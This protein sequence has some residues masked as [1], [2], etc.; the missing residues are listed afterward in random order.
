MIVAVVVAGGTGSRFGVPEGKQVAVVSGLPIVTHT[1]LA[2]EASDSIDAIV[3][4]THPDRVEEYRR[5]VVEELGVS[6]VVAVVA[7]GDTRQDSVA[8]GTEAAGDDATVLV[9]HDGARPLVTPEVIEHAVRT[10]LGDT[11]LDGVIVGHPAVD[12]IHEVSRDDMIE[13]TPDRTR[14]WTAQT[15]QVFRADVL[16]KALTAAGAVG[17]AGTDDASLV[18][19][20]GGSVRMIE[21]PRDNIKVTLPEDVVLVEYVLRQRNERGE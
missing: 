11:D 14:L 8:R 9:V 1:L 21:G 20:N 13:S 16:R 17:H 10:L 6:K 12:T 2:F 19:R 4:V 7:G 5:K 3:L 18:R 15:P